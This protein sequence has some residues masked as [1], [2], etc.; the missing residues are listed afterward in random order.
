MK[1]G[2]KGEQKG[3][4]GGGE[5]SCEALSK[6]DGSCRCGIVNGLVWWFS[7]Y[8]IVVLYMYICIYF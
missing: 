6:G 7:I 3:L 1:F 8:S 2:G 5:F 4:M